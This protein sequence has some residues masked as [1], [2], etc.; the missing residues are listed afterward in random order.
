MTSLT[1]PQRYLVVW[2]R[3]A[4][5]GLARA[6]VVA[7][8]HP[9]RLDSF[10]VDAKS[11]CNHTT[12]E[13]VRLVL[14]KAKAETKRHTTCFVRGSVRGGLKDRWQGTAGQARV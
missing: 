3:H 13:S 5:G 7:H 11:L 4:Q 2:P 10:V 1:I 9:S 8:H 6:P 12:I 14:H